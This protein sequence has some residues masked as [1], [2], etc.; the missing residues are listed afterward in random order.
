MG[1]DNTRT[2]AARITPAI[3]VQLKRQPSLGIRE[4]NTDAV[5]LVDILDIFHDKLK[6]HETGNRY[7]I[8]FITITKE[9]FYER[10]MALFTGLDVYLERGVVV[11]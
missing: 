5:F 9:E 10:K 2:A 6:G 4:R 11:H 1:I 7:I 8:G 3:A